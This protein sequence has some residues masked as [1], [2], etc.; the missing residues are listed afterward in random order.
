MGSKLKKLLSVVLLIVFV[1]CA[2]QIANDQMTEFAIETAAILVGQE[3]QGSF[4]W[5]DDTEQYYQ[6]ILAG[7]LTL[8]GAK[9]AEAYL[10]RQMNPL[11]ANRLIRLAAMAGFDLD[12]AGSIAGVANVDMTLLQAAARGFKLGLE[13]E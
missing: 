11:V 12:A 5:T 4:D 9:I 3:V 6:Y 8:E 10:A 13:L 2:G 1:G 7:K